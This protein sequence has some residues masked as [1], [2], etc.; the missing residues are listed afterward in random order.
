MS[1]NN[2]TVVYRYLPE[3]NYR[4]LWRNNVTVR[5]VMEGDDPK[6]IPELPPEESEFMM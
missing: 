4:A 5:F 1:K 6:Y 3:Y 2:N